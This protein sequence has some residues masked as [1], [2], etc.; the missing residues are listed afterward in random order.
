MKFRIKGL[1]DAISESGSMINSAIS[2]LDKIGNSVGRLE[3]LEKPEFNIN[4]SDE[5]PYKKLTP[6]Q[7]RDLAYVNKVRENI[8]TFMYLPDE[9]ET[10]EEEYQQIIEGGMVEYKKMAVEILKEIIK[11]FDT[12][13]S[14]ME[15][16]KYRSSEEMAK[17]EQQELQGQINNTKANLKSNRPAEGEEPTMA[18][19]VILCDLYLSGIKSC[20]KSAAIDEDDMLEF[21]IENPEEN[22]TLLELYI[23]SQPQTTAEKQKNVQPDQRK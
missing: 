15:G 23:Q 7:L 6:E 9:L 14:W 21:I 13:L 5:S 1:D 18:Q 16:K 11:E 3:Q 8:L 17:L 10:F 22:A 19:L 2:F 4:L 12:S 20:N